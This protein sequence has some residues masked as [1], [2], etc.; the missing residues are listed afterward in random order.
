MSD[1]GLWDVIVSTFWFM[2]LLSWIWLIISILG[3][4]FRDREL[5]GGAKALWTV[6]LIFLPWLGAIVY[7]IARGD[8][9][10]QRAQEAAQANE[11][12]MRAYV[13][14]AAGSTSV[15]DQLRELADLRDQQAITVAEYEQAKLKVLA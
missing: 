14:D 7:L 12:R 5:N 15:T 4:I 13:K 1:F 2:L 8:S 6:F 11:A 3:D 9:M 10:N